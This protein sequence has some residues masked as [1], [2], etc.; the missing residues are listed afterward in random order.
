[1]VWTVFLGTGG[2][3]KY[4]EKA[5]LNLSRFILPFIGDKN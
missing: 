1:M 5:E 4:M 2:K 3:L